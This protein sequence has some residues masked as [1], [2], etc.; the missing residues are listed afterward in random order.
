LIFC[1]AN[2]NKPEN[3][4]RR[5]G[6]VKVVFIKGEDRESGALSEKKI[7]IKHWTKQKASQVFENNT[8]GNG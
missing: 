8:F 3:R 5:I 4:Y 6:L 1:F 2:E 7:C